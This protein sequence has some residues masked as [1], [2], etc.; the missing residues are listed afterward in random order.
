MIKTIAIVIAVALAA[1]LTYA[2]FKPDTFHID[3]SVTINAPAGK[4][5]PLIDDFHRWTA[6]SAYET[7]D[8]QMKRTFS[9]AAAGAGAVYEYDGNSDVGAGR[10]EIVE[11]TLPSK[12]RIELHF[13]KPMEAHNVATF[14]LVPQGDATQVTGRWTGPHRTRRRSCRA[15]STWTR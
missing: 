13:L 11:S 3:R 8:P 5:F 4:I 6:W 12:L 14:T 1:F 7:R 2:S 15:S 10:L 9:G